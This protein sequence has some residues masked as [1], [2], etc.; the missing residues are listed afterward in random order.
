[1]VGVVEGIS[2]PKG[3]MEELVFFYAYLFPCKIRID[4]QNIFGMKKLPALIFHL[5]S[6]FPEDL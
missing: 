5:T 6:S 1:M 3:P 2:S 4:I